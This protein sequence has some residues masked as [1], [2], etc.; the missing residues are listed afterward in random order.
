[1]TRAEIEVTRK[2]VD[3]AEREAKAA[4]E[5]AYQALQCAAYLSLRGYGDGQML[6]D[7]MRAQTEAYKTLKAAR[8]AYYVALAVDRETAPLARDNKPFS[9]FK[10]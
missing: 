6:V 10:Q 4:D 9:I 7:A 1:M 5:A 8:V 3:A 2:A